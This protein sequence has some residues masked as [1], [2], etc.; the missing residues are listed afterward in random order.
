MVALVAGCGSDS[1]ST[2]GSSEAIA[3]FRIPIPGGEAP[4][5]YESKMKVGSNGLSGGEP[6]PSFPQGPAPD[7]LA[8][9]DLIEG[10]GSLSFEGDRLTV[11]YVGYDYETHEKFASSWDEGKAFT[12]TL[13]KGEAIDGW[14]EGLVE[15]EGGD[16]RELVVPPSETSG[17]FPTG[18]PEG[19]AAIFVVEQVPTNPK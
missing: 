7:F 4:I 10:I 11:Q 18:I 15:L 2:G 6:K 13:G 12:L 16:S 17:P 5:R 3:P 9:A 8:L 1:T 14:E 19:H